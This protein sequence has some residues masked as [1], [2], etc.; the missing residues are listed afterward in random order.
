MFMRWSDLAFLH[1]RVPIERLR[2]LVP[3]ALTIDTFDGQAYVGVVP[4]RMEATRWRWAPPVP[5][6]T[7]FPETN[8]RTYVR[9]GD[10][11]GVWFI[12]LDAASRLAVWGARAMLNLPYF[13]ASM[14]LERDGGATVAASARSG[15]VGG[16]GAFEATYRGVGDT[17]TAD[18]GTIDHW[19]A[20]RYCL[21]GQHRGGAAYWMDVHH[22][23]WP[24]RR[25]EVEIRRNTLAA[26]GGVTLPTD[27][28][29]VHVTDGVDVL[30]WLPTTARS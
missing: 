29:I 1:W 16:V 3:E 2:P 12:S 13:H 28:P 4:F 6:A 24:L 23:P 5:T 8:V 19:L 22:P 9:H 10:R 11:A 14:T 26:A 30:A 17:F 7:V 27:A 21:F 25:G 18:P 15:G 20:E